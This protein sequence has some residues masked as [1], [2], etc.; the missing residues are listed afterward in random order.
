MTKVI[1]PENPQDSI[2]LEIN[3]PS[4]KGAEGAAKSFVFAWWAGALTALLDKEFDVKDV[5]YDEKDN[6][7]KSQIKAR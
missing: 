3:N 5:I 7:L 1:L 4:V 2:Q 6:M